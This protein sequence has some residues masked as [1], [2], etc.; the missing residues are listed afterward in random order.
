MKSVLLTIAF[1][2]IT[3]H[4]SSAQSQQIKSDFNKDGVI[5]RVE[6]S[7][8][9]GSSLSSKEIMFIDGKTKKRYGFS[10]WYS[11]GSFFAICNA[12]NVLGKSG[13]EQIGNQLFGYRDTLDASLHWL[14]DACS[15]SVDVKNTGIVNFATSYKPIWIKGEP[16]ISDG[17]YAILSNDE[18]K[19]L[20]QKVEASPDY[21]FAKMKSDYFWI[22]Y[23]TQG[24]SM[25]RKKNKSRNSSGFYI[26]PMDSTHWVYTTDNGVVLKKNDSYSW[27]FIND[28]KLLA[29]NEKLRWPSIDDAQILNDYVLVQYSSN[30]SNSLFIV[31]PNTGFVIGLSNG[32]MELSSIEKMEVDKLKETVEL[33]DSEGKKYLLTLT[34]INELFK[35]LIKP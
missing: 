6:I 26:T 21:D 7:E 14:I 32:L 15:N 12:P 11:F 31:N 8:D 5:D 16:V 33:S 4:N 19:G 1:I 2:A 24:H 10:I 23:N 9:G 20:L 13:R 34:K 29:G 27:V 35:G 28:Y 30:I 18:Y 22:D 3:F 17:Y 25:S